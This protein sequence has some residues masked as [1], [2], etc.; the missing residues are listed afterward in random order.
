MIVDPIGKYPQAMYRVSLKAIIR[1][2]KG[3]VLVVREDGD[4]WS[5]PGGG[6]DHGED[7]MTALKRELYEETLITSEFTANFVGIDTFYVE[8]RQ[9]WLMWIVYEVILPDGYKYGVGPD[10]DEVAFMDI[11]SFEGSDNR[12]FKLTHKWAQNSRLE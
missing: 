12:G 1:N 2:E 5:L 7:V 9:R 4:D 11:S 10:A 6:V 3:E 8:E